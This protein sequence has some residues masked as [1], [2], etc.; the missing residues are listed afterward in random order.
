HVRHVQIKNDAIQQA[1]IDGFQE[2]RT[3]AERLHTQSG[4][5][6]QPHQCFADGF[7]VV[8]DGDERRSFGHEGATV[9]QHKESPLLDLRLLYFSL[10]YFSLL[11]F[12]LERVKQNCSLA[13]ATQSEAA[14]HLSLPKGEGRVRVGSLV[15]GA[16]KPLTS[17]L[18]PLE[19]ERRSSARAR[20]QHYLKRSSMEKG[21]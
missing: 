18:S 21:E 17:I 13:V 2:F 16:R 11:Y 1:R 19:W 6:H 14:I 4:G 12:R 10:S 7:F 8:N 9:A 20:L 15:G 5:T 3:G